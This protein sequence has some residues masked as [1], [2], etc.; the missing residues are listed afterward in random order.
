M[1]TELPPRLLNSFQHLTRLNE[2]YTIYMISMSV[3][4]ESACDASHEI[5]WREIDTFR[6]MHSVETDVI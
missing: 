4:N 3:D 6:K 1:L 5:T 2:E